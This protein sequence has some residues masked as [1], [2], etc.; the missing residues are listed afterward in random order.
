MPRSIQEQLHHAAYLLRQALSDSAK[1]PQLQL[2]KMQEDRV[3]EALKMLG[4][5]DEGKAHR[6]T[7]ASSSFE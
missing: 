6:K 7:S 3:K 2:H 4:E 1:Y 5:E